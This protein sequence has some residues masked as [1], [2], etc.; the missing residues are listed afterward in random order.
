[1]DWIY[2][3]TASD[4]QVPWSIVSFMG[5]PW[6]KAQVAP[7][8]LKSWNLREVWRC[9]MSDTAFRWRIATESV[10]GTKPWCLGIL[11]S[12]AL[13]S[14]G[15]SDSIFCRAWIGHNGE[16]TKNGRGMVW[17][18]YLSCKVFDHLMMMVAALWEN[19]TSPTASWRVGSKDVIACGK[20]FE[21]LRKEKK[22]SK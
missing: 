5:T 14:P 7:T 18:F 22:A 6:L 15:M 4:L 10:S 20:I 1:M 8:L 9:N 19:M 11:K 3:Q 17:I 21:I 2:V 13:E 12:G 16:W